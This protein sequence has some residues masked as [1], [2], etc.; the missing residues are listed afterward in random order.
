MTARVSTIEY[1]PNRTAK[2]SLLLYFDG[3][4]SY[5]LS[6]RGIRI[7][8]FVSSD[9]NVSISLGNHT[10][11]SKIPVGTLIHNVEFQE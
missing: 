6:P 3:E 11:L 9:F 5:I 10:T 2:I 1:D 8:S 4:K 7:G